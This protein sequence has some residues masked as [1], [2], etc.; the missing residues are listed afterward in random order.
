VK[1]LLK[2]SGVQVGLPSRPLHLHCVW[3]HQIYVVC[4]IWPSPAPGPRTHLFW[5]VVRSGGS[6]LL[7]AFSDQGGAPAD[8]QCDNI[9]P[10]R[11][12]CPGTEQ[13]VPA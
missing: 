10:E 12:G 8:S 11:V 7:A 9:G 2:D 13:Q 5:W 3:C 4:T 1:E 6:P